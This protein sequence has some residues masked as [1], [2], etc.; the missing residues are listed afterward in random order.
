M[1]TYLRVLSL[2]ELCIQ[3][4]LEL[5]FQVLLDGHLLPDGHVFAEPGEVPLDLE[6]GVEGAFAEALVDAVTL[7]GVEEAFPPR[8]PVHL[9]LR[10]QETSQNA[11][12]GWIFVSKTRRIYRDGL[13]SG[14]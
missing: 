11:N 14:P 4:V 2:G 13:K 7:R 10:G 6:E 5:C 3:G 12:V 9:K 8:H 1:L